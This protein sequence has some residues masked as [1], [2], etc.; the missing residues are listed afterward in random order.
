MFAPIFFHILFSRVLH[1]YFLN[2]AFVRCF[3]L[4]T[5]FL[6]FIC[7]VLFFIEIQFVTDFK[8]LMKIIA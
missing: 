3:E 7:F 5:T 2:N 1:C 4:K 6:D 8:L